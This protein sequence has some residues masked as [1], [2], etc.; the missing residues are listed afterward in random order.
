V[1]NWAAW[2]GFGMTDKEVGESPRDAVEK[3]I[4]KL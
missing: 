3:L 1:K 4:S 2:K